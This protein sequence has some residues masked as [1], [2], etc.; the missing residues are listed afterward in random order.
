MSKNNNIDISKKEKASKS[1]WYDQYEDMFTL[2]MKPI[3][4]AFIERLAVEMLEWART[5]PNA[6][7]IV[8]F[9]ADKGISAQ[10]YQNWLKKYDFFE[11]AYRQALQLIGARREIGGLKKEYDSGIVRNTMHHFDDQYIKD[12]EWRAKL[13]TQ[14][15]EQDNGTK[16][17]VIERMPETDIVKRKKNEEN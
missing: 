2:Q 8:T 7:K 5:N 4:P 3:N 6:L 16:I 13:R 10:C 14:A 1:K 11:R 15:S 12:E 9:F 17:V